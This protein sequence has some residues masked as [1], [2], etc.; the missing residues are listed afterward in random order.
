MAERL[1]FDVFA[2]TTQAEAGFS[3]LG[4]TVAAS[5]DEVMCLAR[6]M[7]EISR[8]TA[9]AR[10]KLEGDA[11]AQAKLDKLDLKMA[12]VSK[13]VM[14]PKVS[15]EGV[16]K[17][18]VELTGLGLEID[19]LAEKS[20]TA[21]GASGLG[22][23]AGTGGLAGGGLGAVIAAGVALSPVIATVATGLAGFGAAAVAVGAPIA[24]AAQATGGLQAN[25]AKLNPEQQQVAQGLLGL[26]QQFGAFEKKMAP[27]VFTVFNQGLKLASTL[28]GDVEPVAATTGKALGGMLGQIGAEFKSGEWQQFFGFMAKTAGPDIQ[29]LTQNFVGLLKVLPPLLESLQPVATTLL[30]DTAGLLNLV[31]ATE[32]A[33]AAEHRFGQEASSNTGWLGK[34]AHATGQAFN[35]LVPGASGIK[36]VADELGKL[37]DNSGAA[38][39]GLA[40][41]GQ[42]AAVAGPKFFSL[43]AAV[44]QLNNS[45]TKL[46]GNLLT[47]QGSELAWKQ[48]LQA[49][50][51]QLKSNSAGLAGNSRNALANRQ[52]V[53]ASTQAAVSFAQQELTT[54]KDIGGASRTVQ[55][56]IRFLQGLHDKSAFVRAELAA[57]RREEQLL[58][59]Q[60]INQTINVH[61]LGTWSVTKSLAP[62]VG[63]RRATGGLV[64]G[65]GGGDKWPALLEG[66]EAIVPKHLTPMVAPFLK[67]HKVPGFAAGGLVPSYK[68]TPAMAGWVKTD[69][70]A[71]I[72]LID[73]A[74]V[75]AT[76]AGMKAAQT[77]ALAAFSS[78]PGGHFG[79]G[80]QQW[81]GLVARAL[82]MEHLSPGLLRNVLYQMQTESGGNPNAI[83]L[84]DINAR[85]GD[86]SRGLMQTIGSTF[87]AYHWPGTSSNIYDPF[88]NIAAALN[89]AR[90]VYGPS[91]MRG[92][93]GIGSGHGYDS[94]GY[95]PTGASIAI[96]RTGQ[97]ERVTS[98]GQE[99]AMLAALGRIEKLLQSAPERT[100]G[101]LGNALHGAARSARYQGMYSPRGA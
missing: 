16:A 80:V 95:L 98:P 32:K 29:L 55:A 60:R 76:V 94:G 91:L 49:A 23:L 1:E 20:A 75:K 65:Y 36:H 3:R 86:P 66:G 17:A 59:A 96:N 46:V 37:G 40:V 42:A 74:V 99:T 18:S 58:Q 43:N 44:R 19:H 93:M 4:K 62:G 78:R 68:G 28:L 100:G 87:A 83:N 24:K 5:S 51:T 85:M 26:G 72:K 77:A 34:L 15:V 25:M 101:A 50:E 70:A 63:H 84:G 10:V 7:D 90:H 33:V 97:P 14:D 89:Y 22:G 35:E 73:L 67:A 8:K 38:G 54:G 11:D 39:K 61:G 31:S 57:L 64:P 13:R 21:G 27:A 48:S 6:R 45:M 53:L 69:D 81:A 30:K 88:A 71:T 47:L 56:Q 9:T 41:S 12:M 92:G 79:A 52:A 2:K 82:A